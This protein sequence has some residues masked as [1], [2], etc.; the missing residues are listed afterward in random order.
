MY[1]KT[2]KAFGVHFWKLLIGCLVD[3]KEITEHGNATIPLLKSTSSK[4]KSQ[5][6]SIVRQKYKVKKIKH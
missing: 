3:R 4:K 2:I 6:V 5:N 1:L